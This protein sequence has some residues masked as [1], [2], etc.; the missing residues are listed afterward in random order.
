MRFESGN[1]SSGFIKFREF[2]GRVR[3]FKAFKKDVGNS[4]KR[5]QKTVV[6]TGWF[7]PAKAR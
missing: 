4:C 7:E 1:E 6:L 2:L 5:I 3:K